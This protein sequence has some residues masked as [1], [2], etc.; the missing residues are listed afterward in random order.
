MGRSVTKFMDNY[1]YFRE[2]HL[3]K[4]LSLQNNCHKSVTTLDINCLKLMRQDY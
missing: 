4:T 3:S 1:S 2:L